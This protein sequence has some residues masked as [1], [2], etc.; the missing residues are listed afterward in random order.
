MMKKDERI[1]AFARLGKRIREKDA[2]PP[3]VI[4][5]A[6]RQNPWF[7]EEEI[8]F[9]LSEIGESLQQEKLEQWQASY[10]TETLSPKN[11]AVIMAGNIPLVGFH[12]FMSVL[13]SGHQLTGRLSSDDKLLL[14]A[15]AKLLLEEEARFEG[16]FVL[17]E[18]RIEGKSIDAVIATGSNNS[19]RYFEYY[20][21]KYPHIIRKNRHGVAVLTGNE[22]P[23]EL[24]ALGNDIFRYFGLGCRNVTKLFV[25]RGYV[26]NSFFE[27]IVGWGERA[28]AHTKYM[29]NYEYHRSLYLL[30]NEA[31]LDNNFLL[32]KE[33]SRL[34]S[35]PGVLY[36]EYYDEPAELAERFRIDRENIQCI[37]GE[38][39]SG[40]VT[41][42]FGKSQ[43]PGLADYA[44]GVDTMAFLVEIG[45]R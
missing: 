9:M 23:E 2:L 17:A 14:P 32:L 30:N 33:D 4:S 25:P 6:S 43:S 19:A 38:P 18:G 24:A 41:V 27:S 44:D 11:V 42:P 31:L 8:R 40:V 22:S 10:A 35:P 34:A 15:V 12:D 7:C 13:L 28:M 16:R 1:S 45:R 5:V 3:E 39:F 36:Y 37:V 26:F 29:N 21:S 20:F